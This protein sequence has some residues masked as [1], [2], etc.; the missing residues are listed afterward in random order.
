LRV[1]VR[2]RV[3]DGAMTDNWRGELF[4]LAEQQNGAVGLF[5]SVPLQASDEQRLR[6]LNGGGWSAPYPGVRTRR[7][8]PLTA[9]LRA[10]AAV[11]QMG[12]DAVL[13]H[14]SAAAWWGLPGFVLEPYNVLR[15]RGCNSR[16]AKCALAVRETRRLPQHHVTLLKGVP[17]IRP[18][19]L[20]FELIQ[21]HSVAKVEVVVDR[22]IQRRL[23]TTARLHEMLGE[24]GGRGS[25]GIGH[26]RLL[27]KSRPTGYVPPE[28]GAESRMQWVAKRYGLPELRPQVNLGTDDEWVARVD[29]CIGERL[30]IWVQSDLYHTALVDRRKDDAQRVKLQAQGFTVLEVWQHEL[31]DNPEA[32]AR[33]VR[34]ELTALEAA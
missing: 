16:K 3:H 23:T 15:L 4:R 1:T 10:S 5:Q 7:G 17:I 33:R 24:L 27:M 29:F 13:S 18:E 21:N 8:A 6:E 20:P 32:I 30:V 28:S 31:W 12:P 2:G 34:T 14:E 19:R 9:G 11:L 25:K 26:L 22:L